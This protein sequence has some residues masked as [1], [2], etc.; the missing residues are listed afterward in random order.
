MSPAFSVGTCSSMMYKE[1][2]VSGLCGIRERELVN[3]GHGGVR[4]SPRGDTGLRS[5]LGRLSDASYLQISKS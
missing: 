1:G 4:S 5:T 3:H 2:G